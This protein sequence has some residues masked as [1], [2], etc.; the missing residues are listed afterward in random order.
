MSAGPSTRT[1]AA[2]PT[3]GARSLADDIRSRTDEQLTALVLSRPDLARPAPSD[4]TSLAARAGTRASVQRAIEGLDLGHLQVLEAVVVAGDGS[5]SGSVDELIGGLDVRSQLQ[6]LWDLALVW[7]APEGLYAVR[8]APEVLGA[9]PAGLG[10]SSLELGAKPL[11]APE[12]QDLVAE[13]PES[14]RGVLDRLVWG[15]PVGVVNRDAPG[16]EGVRWLLDQR[17]LHVVTPTVT[18]RAR[19]ESE[20]RV[21]LPREVAL[22]LRGGRLHETVSLTPPPA[23]TTHVGVD[24]VDAAAG[25]EVSDLLALVEE[26]IELWGP[27][28]PRVLRTGGLAVRDLRRLSESLDVDSTRAAWLVEVMYGAGLVAD[29]GEIVPVWAPTPVADEWLLEPSGA[30]WARLAAAWLTS[31]RAAHLVGSRLGGSSS[32]ANAL[33]PDLHWPPVRAMRTDVLAELAGLDPGDVATSDS[34]LARLR[35]RR[36][37]RNPARLGDAMGA[38]LREA[39]W[40]GVTGRGGL[41]TSGRALVA[42]EDVDAVAATMAGQLPEPVDHVLVQADLTAIAPGPL[43]GELAQLMRLVADVESRGG[44]TVHRFTPAS[45]RRALDAGWT[46][47]ELLESLR[48]A[49]R[50]GLPQPLEYLVRDVARRHGQTR[51]GGATAYIRSD[52]ESVLESLLVE[53]ALNA[54]RLRRIAPTVLVSSADPE[55]LLELMREAGYSPVQERP[56]G[57]VVVSVAARRRAATRRAVPPA[58]SSPVDAGYAA[59]L[60]RG[61]RA[62]EEA[63]RNAE[64]EDTRPTLVP[65]DPAVTMAALRDAAAEQH[66]VWIGY[67]DM[68]G[69]TDRYLFYPT[70][71]EGGRAWGRVADSTTER[72]FSVYR[73]TGVA[74]LAG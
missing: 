2:E 50:T 7:R 40:L 26:A 18:E 70:R 24:R 28:P 55:M 22:L 33:S 46:A 61:L 69:R 42:G 63:S 1:D 37:L 44:A 67:A 58:R 12:V 56:D 73:I 34:L 62:A 41:S 54:L 5:G 43:H 17:L 68:T 36:P 27:A 16:S 30:R 72:G 39:E 60:V 19:G 11:S 35:W 45:V 66:G 59:S 20:T 13:A 53:R 51:V 23:E 3:A 64:G 65:S 32:P 48:G 6:R 74:D 47:D 52:D 38:V 9:H 49:S 8:T 25:G 57:S 71:V 29:D 10:P 21:L 4:L 15:P 14:A 31:T